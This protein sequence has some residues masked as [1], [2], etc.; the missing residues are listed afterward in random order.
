MM[1]ILYAT[2]HA[3]YGGLSINTT[4]MEKSLVC[5]IRTFTLISSKQ[6]ETAILSFYLNIYG[7]I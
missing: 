2:V 5:E 4:G 3:V 7:D 6:I 1:M